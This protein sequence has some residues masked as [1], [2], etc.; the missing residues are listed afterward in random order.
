MTYEQIGNLV[1]AVLSAVMG[2]MTVQFVIF[3]LVGIFARR[4][5]PKAKVKHKYGLIIPARNEEAV[6]GNL[7]ESMQKTDYPQELLHIFV[8]A[9]NCTDRTAEVARQL[10]ATVYEY[11]NPKENTMGYAFKYLFSCIERDYGTQNYD[12]F[13]LFNADNILSRDYFDKM[14]DAF[15]ACGGESVITSFRNSKNFGSNMMSGMY[16]LFFMFGCRFESRGRT[17]C[18][19]STR[20]QGTGYVIN[21]K[22]VKDGWPYVTLTEDWEFSADQIL[23]GRKIVYCDEAVFYDEQP[24]TN[25][26]MLRQRLRWSKGH[27]LVCLT[28]C[29]L[30]FKSLF[31]KRKI[32]SPNGDGTMIKNNKYSKY[33]IFVNCLP[34]FFVSAVLAILSFLFSLSVVF[35]VEDKT[36]YLIEFAIKSGISLAGAYVALVFIAVAIFV[37]ENKRIH[38]VSIPKRIG[39][40]LLFPFFMF[41]GYVLEFIA[42]FAKDVQWKPI[43]HNDTT[44]H[45]DLNKP[46]STVIESTPIAL[47]EVATVALEEEGEQATLDESSS[48]VSNQETVTNDEEISASDEQVSTTEEE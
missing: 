46:K 24:T 25:R 21:S 27:L 48:G 16:G 14:N 39:M 11:N 19:C 10:G 33:D 47:E 42:V 1:F 6:V 41:V 18:G 7:I 34:M 28:R 35:F 9:H 36:Q 45:E 44:T 8:I 23:Q 15:D 31:G 30:L 4:K 3:A 40:A 17:V 29:K 26:V 37:L 12:G 2:L 13:F 32:P 43:P 22:I 5:F 20:V 38:N